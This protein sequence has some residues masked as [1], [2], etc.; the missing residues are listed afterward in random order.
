[1]TAASSATSKRF[2]GAIA[3]GL[4]AGLGITAMLMAGERKSRRPSELAELERTGAER[5]GLETPSADTLPD[6]REQAIVQGGHLALSALAGAAFA[7]SIDEEAPVIASGIGFGLAF[8][9]VAHWLVGPLLGLKRPEWQSGGK[10]IAM[11]TLN[12]VGFGLVT[13]LSARVATKI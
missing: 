9:G 12:H 8:Y 1:M 13:A 3:G 7:A 6:A 11:H 2:A 10:T 5:L 4:I